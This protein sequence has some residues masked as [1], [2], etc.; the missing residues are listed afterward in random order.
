MVSISYAILLVAV[1]VVT[2]K[3][4]AGAPKAQCVWYG[5]CQKVPDKPSQEYNCLYQG[6]PKFLNDSVPSEHVA[7]KKINDLCPSMVND[8]NSEF[9]RYC[10]KDVFCSVFRCLCMQPQIQMN[11]Y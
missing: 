10:S 6:A 5:N 1:V 7:L 8:T 3:S 4:D 11:E 9:L 2:C